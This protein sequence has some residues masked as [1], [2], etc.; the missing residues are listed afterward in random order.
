MKQEAQKAYKNGDYDKAYMIYKQLAKQNDPDA[1]TSMGF[2]YHNG[3]SV[4]RDF[5][6]AK[7]WYEKAALHNEPF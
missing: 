3:Q 1:M 5:I 4:E 2:F 6:K 7:E